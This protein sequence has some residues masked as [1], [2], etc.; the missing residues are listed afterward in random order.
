MVDVVE[1][2][3]RSRMMSGIRGKDT[4]PELIVRRYL[5]ANG[6]RFRIH[7]SAL[8][9]TP[10]VVLPKYRLAILVHGCY[11]HRH[12][13]CRLTSFPDDPT[14]KWATKFR[15]TIERDERNMSRLRAAGWRVFVLWEC[16]LQK[17]GLVD[18]LDWLPTAIQ[19]MSIERLEWPEVESSH[20]L[21]SNV[22]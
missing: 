6:F 1:K 19:D 13:G 3:V 4:Q 11:W 10:D 16:G 14:G 5:H 12:F 20:M 17:R 2:S 15:G 8:P 18:R 9:G 7:V 22:S 21:A